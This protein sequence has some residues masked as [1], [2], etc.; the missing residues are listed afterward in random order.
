[1]TKKDFELIASIIYRAMFQ[2]RLRKG[3]ELIEQEIENIAG[4]FTQ[5]LGD[6]YPRFDR[7]KFLLAC[8]VE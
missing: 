5:T 2:A 6:L 1:M 4:D 8:G 7:N 3:Q